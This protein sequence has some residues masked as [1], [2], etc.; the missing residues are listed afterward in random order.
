MFDEIKRENMKHFSS[1]KG[2]SAACAKDFN[3]D[4][5][6]VCVQRSSLL[7]ELHPSLIVKLMQD[8]NKPFWMHALLHVVITSGFEKYPALF[9]SEQYRNSHDPATYTHSA[10]LPNSLS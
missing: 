9:F 6:Y 5:P 4:T 1:T 7:L 2:A 10:K 8:G 3:I